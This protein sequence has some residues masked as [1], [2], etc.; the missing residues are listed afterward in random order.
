MLYCEQANN[1]LK[2]ES[3][4]VTVEYVVLTAATLGLGLA[5]TG[6]INE[7][8][9]DMA[10]DVAANLSGII[11]EPLGG[12][13]NGGLTAT[14]G[15]WVNGTMVDIAGFGE[16]M[17]L[18]Q[19]EMTENVIDIPQGATSA[20]FSFDVISGDTLDMETSFFYI[21]GQLV[22]HL[23]SQSRPTE[24]AET[25]IAGL[26][27]GGWFPEG[28]TVREE[29]IQIGTNIGGDPNWKDAITRVHITMDNPTS[30]VTFGTTTNGNEAMQNEFHAIDNFTVQAN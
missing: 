19:N 9:L 29:T 15:N 28:F 6:V 12:L 1:F 13:T 7:G 27:G 20:T 11:S 30:Q 25:N 5:V 22:A 17:L 16:V 3:G 8:I 4:A 18:R 10:N 14:I 21:N 2:D 26:G 24:S 23:N